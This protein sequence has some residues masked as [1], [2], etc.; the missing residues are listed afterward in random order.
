MALTYGFYDSDDGDRKYSAA[1]MNAIF[2]GLINDGVFATVEGQFSVVPQS[3]ASMKVNVKPGKAWFKN[4]WTVSDE[5]IPLTIDVASSTYNRKDSIVLEID[6]RDVGRKNSI[7]VLKGTNSTGT[8]QSINLLT[9]ETANPGIYYRRLANVTVNKGATTI[10][11]ADIEITVGS[12][13]T[14]FVT[15]LL[16]VNDID[17]LFQKWQGDFDAWFENVQTQL[18]DDVAGNLLNLINGKVNMSDRAT[19][20]EAREGSSN[21]KWMTPRGT[22]EAIKN[23]PAEQLADIYDPTRVQ[24]DVFFVPSGEYTGVNRIIYT[25]SGARTGAGYYAYYNSKHK[26]SVI[27]NNDGTYSIYKG[28]AKKLLGTIPA[29]G[30]NGSASLSRSYTGCTLINAPDMD[31]VVI[32]RPYG[33]STTHTVYD[34]YLVTE[35]LIYRQP[36]STTDYGIDGVTE[37]YAYI[38]QGDRIAYKLLPINDSDTPMIIE[39]PGLN[40]ASSYGYS[41]ISIPTATQSFA[42][43]AQLLGVA[44][45]HVFVAK[46]DSMNVYIYDIDF[47]NNSINLVTTVAKTDGQNATPRFFSY[48]TRYRKHSD[49]TYTVYYPVL[50]EAQ[51]G[52]SIFNLYEIPK[53]G[54]K[55]ENYESF[56]FNVYSHALVNITTSNGEYCVRGICAYSEPTDSS[57]TEL[58]F[59]DS[60]DRLRCL[61]TMGDSQ[62]WVS[63]APEALSLTSSQKETLLANASLGAV[64]W[65]LANA[66]YSGCFYGYGIVLDPYG[67]Y[68]FIPDYDVF[69]KIKTPLLKTLLFNSSSVEAVATNGGY[70]AAES[71]VRDQYLEIKTVNAVYYNPIVQRKGV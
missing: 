55:A 71:K 11:G 41:I 58:V 9:V 70:G 67:G 23:I 44:G 64:P 62:A 22:K 21:V 43:G 40:A 12:S 15:G 4:T 65:Y 36:D 56:A 45:N 25:H 13:E 6:T 28:I 34:C 42:S 3:P 61:E 37:S 49:D 63:V 29:S 57:F 7:K 17:D 31:Y 38:L 19:S 69:M 14:P 5:I 68:T 10:I 59:L 32:S 27:C 20:I 30:T 47:E 26:V 60:N 1:E 16:E 18:G 33:S 35:N 53:V 24:G 52:W 48:A 8:P 51:T 54:N 39:Q 66:S 46:I 50:W 2:N